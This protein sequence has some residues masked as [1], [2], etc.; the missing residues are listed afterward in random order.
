MIRVFTT[1]LVVY[2]MVTMK[3]K[4]KTKIKPHST[5]NAP[6]LR[7]FKVIL[8][9]LRLLRNEVTLLFPQDDLEDYVNPDRI[10]RSY[11]K[12][13]KKYPPVSSL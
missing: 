9:E 1:L 2:I 11:Q 13:I 5:P 12:A 10:R 6:S 7:I 4:M 3:Q 8:E